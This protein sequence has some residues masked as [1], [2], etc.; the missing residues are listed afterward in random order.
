M[1][2]FYLVA[3]AAIAFIVWFV[4]MAFEGKRSED[5]QA[6]RIYQALEDR[7]ATE[8]TVK[9]LAE[10]GA[11]IGTFEAIYTDTAGVRVKIAC[12]MTGGHMFWSDARSLTGRDSYLLNE[13]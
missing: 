6:K 13:G 12:L 2:V 5:T 8:I 4:W 1:E 10:A 7:G 3:V 11:G 9:R